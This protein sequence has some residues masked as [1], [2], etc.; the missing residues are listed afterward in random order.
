MLDLVFVFEFGIFY[1]L[2]FR[3]F[4]NSGGSAPKGLFPDEPEP[5][6]GPKVKVAIIGS[7]L[8]GLSTA[9]ELLEQGHE[10]RWIWTY[11]QTRCG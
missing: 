3:G 6:L 1:S 9:I 2:F 10:V 7:G 8:A 4:L 5:Y 11:I